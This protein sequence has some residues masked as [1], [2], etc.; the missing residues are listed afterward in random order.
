MEPVRVFAA[1]WTFKLVQLYFLKKLI[2][3]NSFIRFSGIVYPRRKISAVE[4]VP[5]LEPEEFLAEYRK[6]D[7]LVDASFD[8][9]IRDSL[10]EIFSGH[11]IDVVELESFLKD[12]AQLDVLNEVIWPIQGLDSE[13]LR[14]A[15]G[16]STPSFFG[17]DRYHDRQSYE[18][19]KNLVD[20]FTHFRWHEIFRYDED[21]TVQH[22]LATVFVELLSDCT[23]LNFVLLDSPT[24][25]L[26]AIVSFKRDFPDV[27]VSLH[28]N[29]TGDPYL[30]NQ[31]EYCEQLFGE[32]LHQVSYL[33]RTLKLDN[34]VY[35]CAR[36]A[37]YAALLR[38]ELFVATIAVLTRSIFDLQPFRAI[39]NDRNYSLLLRQPNSNLDNL[40]AALS[41]LE[42]SACR[43][44]RNPDAFP[45]CT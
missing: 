28:M 37:E 18:I 11:G 38:T 32:N 17:G 7:I 33:D 12:T 36:P 10:N 31:K 14:T 15:A 20:I 5:I 45:Q 21:D 1:G 44:S 13:T 3:G 35:L 19:A 26:D 40:I 16:F 9:S 30:A 23:S 34:A 29:K 24:L 25:F 39:R 4:G 2:A 22:A 42:S 41:N 43:S 27:E 8:K 6:G